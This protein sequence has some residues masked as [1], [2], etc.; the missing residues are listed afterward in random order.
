MFESFGNSSYCLVF[1]NFLRFCVLRFNDC[2][3][4]EPYFALFLNTIRKFL[5]LYFLVEK[6]SNYFAMNFNIVKYNTAQNKGLYYLS[7][8]NLA[9]V[10]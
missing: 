2:L 1:V 9:F 4:S 7:L 3:T 8:V 5:P 6:S 10:F